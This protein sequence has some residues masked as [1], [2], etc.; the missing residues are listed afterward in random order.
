MK[1]EN[2]NRLKKQ[3]QELSKL[4]EIMRRRALSNKAKTNPESFIEKNFETA[5]LLMKTKN[6]FINDTPTKPRPKPVKFFSLDSLSQKFS[7]DELNKIKSLIKFAKTNQ[8]LEKIYEKN[9]DITLNDL[10]DKENMLFNSDKDNNYNIKNVL[11]SFFRNFTLNYQK[12][13]S[14]LRNEI[15]SLKVW[16]E[17][18]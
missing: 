3:N 5:S 10:L 2:I 15:L 11:N 8:I 14:K 13:D 18:N 12:E 6:D 9:G 17:L 1:T 4:K 7:I 16:K